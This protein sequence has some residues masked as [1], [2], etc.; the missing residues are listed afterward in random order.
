MPRNNPNRDSTDFV[1]PLADIYALI[2]TDIADTRALTAA[3]ET[4]A[5]YSVIFLS[6]GHPTNN[7]DDEL[8]CR[9]RGHAHSPAQ[10]SW[11]TT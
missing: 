4:R 11:P 6:D 7:Q 10:G 3:T 5:R 2:S 1:K 8:L 9:R